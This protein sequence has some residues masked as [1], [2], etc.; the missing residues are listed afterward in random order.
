MPKQGR[1]G[2]KSKASVDAH[3]KPCCPHTVE[4]P[5]V[6][7][8]PN[9]FVNSQAALREGDKGINEERKCCGTNTWTAKEGSA[10]V[11]INC[12]PAHR[13]DDKTV[14]CGG[15]GNLIE[16]SP[17]VFVGGGTTSL[18]EKLAQQ[19]ELQNNLGEQDK[20]ECIYPIEEAEL[21]KY[22]TDGGCPPLG[23]DCNKGTCCNGNL[24]NGAI[25]E[26]SNSGFRAALCCS[27]NRFVLVFAGTD[28]GFLDR[29]KDFWHGNFPI[30]LWSGIGLNIEGKQLKQAIDLTQKIVE[31][32]GTENLR[33]TGHSLGGG[34]AS[35][36]SLVAGVKA[37]TFNAL[38][39]PEKILKEHNLIQKDICGLITR[40]NNGDMLTVLGEKFILPDP[41]GKEVKLC[42]CGNSLNPVDLF[43]RHANFKNIIEELKRNCPQIYP[44]EKVHL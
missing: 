41:L 20:E 42:G 34:L 26:D 27:K 7:G 37:S 18:A 31:Q 4:G 3:G 19:E 35:V 22:I 16:G 17:D 2:D 15:P 25:L 40:Y 38:G 29:F 23:W 11:F 32:C 5:A 24:L 39:I 10:T 12:K 44:Q 13:L 9:V 33:I 1:V 43:K 30:A 36:A 21:C 28:R 14:H 8:S 6:Q